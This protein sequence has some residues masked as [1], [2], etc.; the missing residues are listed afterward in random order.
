LIAAALLA[1]SCC[2]LPLAAGAATSPSTEL[3]AARH[4]LSQNLALAGSVADEP[5]TDEQ[6]AEA[7]RLVEEG[8]AAA[9][10]HATAEPAAEARHLIGMLLVFAYRPVV[11][12]VPVA[13]DDGTTAELTLTRLRRGGEGDCEQGLAEL[14]AATRL[15]PKNLAYQLDYAEGLQICGEVRRSGGLLGALWLRSP[16]MTVGQRV[17]ASRLLAQVAR[18]QNRP[19]EEARWLREVLTNDPQDEGADQR[20]AELTHAVGGSIFWLDYE[21]GMRAAR[22]QGRPVMVY[23]KSASC[24]LCKKLDR[25]VYADPEV[26]ALSQEFVCVKVDGDRRRDLVRRHRVRGY[27]TILF[28]DPQGRR[29]NRVVGYKPRRPFLS[30]MHKA[31]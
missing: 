31:L 6:A 27:P 20:L 21:A 2:T 18:E 15:A 30:D 23:F 28:L 11:S 12:K 4:A 14:R 5:A 13:N 19:Q 10:A 17:R 29:L 16:E 26:I 1:A 8:L 3:E 9:R 25:E 7:A 22:Q 24:V